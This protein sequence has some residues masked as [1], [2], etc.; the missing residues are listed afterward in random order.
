MDGIKAPPAYFFESAA[1]NKN[2]YKALDQ[3]K[4]QSLVALDLEAFE[5]EMNEGALVIDSRIPDVFEVGFIP[6]SVNIGLN[7]QYA[8]WAAELFSLDRK[9]ILVCDEGKEE[10][11]VTRLARVGF[12]NV[13]GYLK[14][15]FQ[16]WQEAGKETDLMIS[17]DAYE[18]SLDYKHDDIRV[19]DVRKEGEWDTAHLSKAQH[20]CLSKLPGRMDEINEDNNAL[21]IHCAGGYRS[22]IAASL[23]RKNGY[24]LIKNVL[25]GFGKI[26]KEEGLDIISTASVI[27]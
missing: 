9:I 26:K 22:M 6:G 15:G 1:L 3:L 7:G 24:K 23:L 19:L 2:G 5:K 12:Q 21:Y 16:Q 10:E 11:S 18:F 13:R 17:I 14:G 20:I 25:G 8:I 27:S 4:D